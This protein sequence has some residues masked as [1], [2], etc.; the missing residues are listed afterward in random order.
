MRFSNIG[1]IPDYVFGDKENLEKT[2]Q[3]GY[4]S[5][6]EPKNFIE[7]MKYLADV[8]NTNRESALAIANDLRDV[9]AIYET[10]DG[11]VAPE[12]IGN[13]VDLAMSLAEK[14]SIELS[15]LARFGEKFASIEKRAQWDDEREDYYDDIED[16]GNREGWEDAQAEIES[17]WEESRM[18][19]TTDVDEDSY[20]PKTELVFAELSEEYSGGT[21]Q[22][23]DFAIVPEGDGRAWLWGYGE[24]LPGSVLSG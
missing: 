10:T 8:A 11:V 12:N 5:S 9:Y 17:A 14:L 6:V 22:Y 1:R 18:E 24:Y 15:K 23:D 4:A 21:V 2:A 3:I 7:Y 20:D 19:P 13:P 16:L